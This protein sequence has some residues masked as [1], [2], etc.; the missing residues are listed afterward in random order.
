MSEKYPLFPDLPDEGTEEAQKLID[1][2]K[3]QLK[4]AAEEVI[5]S[6]YCEIVPHI[7]SD[8]WTNFRNCLMDGLQNYHN[9]HL[10]APY[11]FKKIRQAIFREYREEIL[12][13]LNSDLAE[14]NEQLKKDIEELLA[15]CSRSAHM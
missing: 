14:E 11:D 7:E 4:K 8:S 10:Q 12:K 2:F 15:Q 3:E 6:F 1:K 9:R 13:D 5:G